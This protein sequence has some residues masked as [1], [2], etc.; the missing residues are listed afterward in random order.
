MTETS[1]TLGA[2]EPAIAAGA[3][4]QLTDLGEQAPFVAK[5][6]T[7]H[8]EICQ[9]P[10][11]IEGFGED[12]LRHAIADRL[13][14]GGSTL[15]DDGNRGH[16]RTVAQPVKGPLGALVDQV[17]DDVELRRQ[18]VGGRPGVAAMAADPL[19]ASQQHLAIVIIRVDD[20]RLQR[21]LLAMRLDRQSARLL[22]AWIGIGGRRLSGSP[23]RDRVAPRAATP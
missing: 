23:G 2:G 12:R 17:E 20:Q 6:V 11:R 10:Y 15:A 18:F 13:E 19:Q 14:N 3:R 1:S 22:V 21:P 4:F 9:Q 16:G 8:Q 7:G 5:I